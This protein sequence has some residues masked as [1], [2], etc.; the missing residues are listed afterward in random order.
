MKRAMKEYPIQFPGDEE[1]EDF[2]DILM[3]RDEDGNIVIYPNL[4]LST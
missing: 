2:L 1:L 3:E 4:D